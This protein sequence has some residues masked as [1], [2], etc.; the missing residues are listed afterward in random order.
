MRQK[1][2]ETHENNEKPQKMINNNNNFLDKCA[3]I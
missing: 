1:L 2:I 3:Y